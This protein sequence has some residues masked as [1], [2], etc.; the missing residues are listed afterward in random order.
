MG[1]LDKIKSKL[2]GGSGESWRDRL[3]SSS[4][5][6][7]EGELI[8][9]IY[10][11]LSRGF[12][13]RGEAWEFA[14]LDGAYVQRSGTGP[15]KYPWRCVFSGP[16]YDRDAL[17]F[18]GALS[19]DGRGVLNHP[20]FGPVDVI[21][22]GEV[23][24]RD[25]LAT[26]ANEAVI[27]VTF[28]TSLE[29]AYPLSGTDLVSEIRSQLDDFQT[30]AAA[31]LGALDRI[32]DFA[33]SA[34]VLSVAQSSLNDINTILTELSNTTAQLKR[35]QD[36]QFR[37]VD[38][39]LNILIEK[40][41]DLVASVAGLVL[42]PAEAVSDLLTKTSSYSRLGSEIRSK[43]S[44][45]SDDSGDPRARKRAQT[46]FLTR[47]MFVSMSLA[48]AVASSI[49]E[50]SAPRNRGDATGAAES[51]LNELEL[52]RTWRDEREDS[53]DSLDTLDDG[54]SFL[55]LQQAVYLATSRLIETSFSLT[56][57]RVYVPGKDTTILQLAA[58]LYGDVED[59]TLNRIINDNEMTADETVEVK[60]G[61][62]VK[63]YPAA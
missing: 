28:W 9:L 52:V 8:P 47:E 46:D 21:P 20:I 13:L 42:G 15:R 11:D 61:R 26:G 41:A 35:A 22:L 34:S 62:R 4:Y 45:L 37:A 7:P 19:E 50:S 2:I 3:Q 10:F 39:A 44:A 6:S 58:K 23:T 51:L 30:G 31:K 1:I 48:G 54:V 38:N 14:D 25:D 5:K 16:D 12:E 56:Q 60:R 49:S 63:Y 40:P 36:R 24:R 27:E 32:N 29:S 55:A 33:Q 17:A 53:L 43:S 59:E 57:E 18:E